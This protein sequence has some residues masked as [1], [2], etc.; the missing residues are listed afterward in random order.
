MACLA[1]ACGTKNVP[2]PTPVD[3][4]LVSATSTAQHRLLV[5]RV[6]DG[7][8]CSSDAYLQWLHGFPPEVIFTAS[9]PE[10]GAGRVVLNAHWMRDRRRPTLALL[11]DPRDPRGKPKEVFLV[12]GAP[13]EYHLHD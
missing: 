3:P 12:P 13:G 6:C 5:F 10:I 7:G 1:L 8:A 11:V 4:M 2:L 9:V